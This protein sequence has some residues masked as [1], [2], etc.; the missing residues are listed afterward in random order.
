M[1]RTWVSMLTQMD[2]CYLFE[3][4]CVN[5]NKTFKL[6]CNAELDRKGIDARVNEID[7]QIAKITQRKEA[8]SASKR[9]R[10]VKIPY[11]VFNLEEFEKKI[12]SPR[13]K[14]KT[15]YEKSFTIPQD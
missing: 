5:E 15:G 1:Y 7:F 13:V 2:F 9:K 14:D 12:K 10:L 4:I 11:A 8:R 3:Y 6:Q